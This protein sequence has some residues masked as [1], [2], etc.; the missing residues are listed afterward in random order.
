ME[1]RNRVI[2][3]T[4][5]VNY[6]KSIQHQFGYALG[7]C[8]RFKQSHCQHQ[9]K[10]GFIY[11]RCYDLRK[12]RQCELPDYG[13]I[14]WHK[15]VI[16]N[17]DQLDQC[18]RIKDVGKLYDHCTDQKRY[19]VYRRPCV[20]YHDDHQ[21]CSINDHMYIVNRVQRGKQ[22]YGRYHQSARRHQTYG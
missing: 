18:Y 5:T 17:S 15:R 2:I 12:Q 6:S 20:Y 1:Q 9:Q 14:C 7:S 19:I 4:V 11:T 16:H 22:S 13:Y 10:V 21:A 3:N 8:K